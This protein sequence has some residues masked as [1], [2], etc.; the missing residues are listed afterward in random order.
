MQRTPLVHA[1]E[2]RLNT[3]LAHGAAVIVE[4]PAGFGKSRLL[5]QLASRTSGAITVTTETELAALA[6]APERVP[7]PTT[8]L[9]DLD[10]PEVEQVATLANHPGVA[11]LVI[12]GRVVSRA[13]RDVLSPF[14]CLEVT[15][16]DLTLSETEVAELLD[17]GDRPLDPASAEFVTVQTAGW[18]A[19]IDAMATHGRATRTSLLDTPS[20]LRR[21]LVH[22]P[23]VDR[24]LRETLGTLDADLNDALNRFGLLDRFTTTAFDAVTQPGTVRRLVDAGVPILESPDGWL[25]LPLV[26]RQHL[27]DDIAPDDAKRVAPHL[28][29]SGGLLSAAHTLVSSGSFITAER[30][31]LESS[32]AQLED[33]EPR[34]LLGVLD[35]IEP[36]DDRAGLGLVRSRA[37][38]NLGELTEARRVIDEIV[39]STETGTEAWIDARLEQLRSAAMAGDVEPAHDEASLVL[40]TPLHHTRWREIVGL[41]AAQSSDPAEVERSIGLLETAASEWQALG[42]V[43][44]AANV[45]RIMSSIALLHLGRYP[46]AIDATTR[47]RRLSGSRL[48][49]RALSTVLL[50]HITAIA[51]RADAVE[52]EIAAARSLA[53]TVRLPWLEAHIAMAMAVTSAHAGRNDDAGD[54]ASRLDQVLDGATAHPTAALLYA[55]VATALAVAGLRDEANRYLDRAEHL[56]HQA[57]LE[58]DLAAAVVAA[59]GGDIG[60]AAQ[61][62]ET[63]TGDPRVPTSRLWRP[64]LEV[65]IASEDHSGVHDAAA[66]A[67]TLGLGDLAARLAAPASR[68]VSVRVLGGL[69]ITVGGA[70]IT[71]P[72]GR[73]AEL[74]KLLVCRDGTVSLDLAIEELWDDGPPTDVGIRRLKN[75]I[76]RLRE[77]IGADAIIRSSAAIHLG[78]GVD[79]DLARF[80]AAAK[81]ATG[82]GGGGDGVV[83]AVHA[84]NLYE[85]LLPDEP[86]SDLVANRS[87]DLVAT[88]SGL[89]DVVLGQ[90]IDRP[91]SAWLLDKARRIDL[92]AEHWFTEIALLAVEEK[93]LVQARQARALARAAAVEL[94]V[95][96]NPRLAAVDADLTPQQN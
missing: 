23:V 16:A 45:L 90:P 61:L 62:L 48:Y 66:V 33:V 84:L 71:P 34:D 74:L 3:V 64:Q 67:Q 43:A 29:Q 6:E 60:R 77:V 7:A 37:H 81:A 82:H 46:E 12:A 36:A 2:R 50:V 68:T 28:A 15:T 4:A 35:A 42:D 96:E 49:D 59:R 69:A 44:R 88:A 52:R 25:H 39:S 1:D 9:I 41:R 32:R 54:W 31:I 92:F 53:E 83:E 73:P 78:P 85:P 63:L 91:S 89:F 94:G 51:G 5:R 26:L 65:A 17:T 30:L 20:V 79:T 21:G 10:R 40:S 87:M 18:P 95:P 55:E 38:E 11:M 86:H 13:I 8:V 14:G 56:R 72:T 58:I 27:G 80:A 24:V 75:P 76:N 93:N 22:H 70:A 57:P 19:V 47:A